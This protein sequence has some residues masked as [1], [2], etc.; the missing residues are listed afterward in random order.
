MAQSQQHRITND[1]RITLNFPDSR[2]WTKEWNGQIF[3][4]DGETNSK[5]VSILIPNELAEVFELIKYKKDN[6]GRFL[7]INCKILDL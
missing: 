1:P 2:K 3:F 6:Y 4:S 5:V 7:L